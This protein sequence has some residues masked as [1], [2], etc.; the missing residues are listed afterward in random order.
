MISRLSERGLPVYRSAA[1]TTR[2]VVEMIYFL[3]NQLAPRTTMH[4]V[5]VEVYGVGV[6]LTGESG[7]G[8]SEAAL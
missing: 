4:G 3:N 8:K 7:V 2:V 6:L 1:D 5:L